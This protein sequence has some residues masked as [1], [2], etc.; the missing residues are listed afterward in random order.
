MPDDNF[1]WKHLHG[2]DADLVTLARRAGQV[3]R[4]LEM[5]RSHGLSWDETV[6][7]HRVLFRVAVPNDHLESLVADL[8]RERISFGV[9][10]GRTKKALAFSRKFRVD[11]ASQER[12][13]RA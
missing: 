9:F 2:Q 7:G 8:R 6:D 5:A 3:H 11:T 1:V 12:R 4:F 13:L 10:N